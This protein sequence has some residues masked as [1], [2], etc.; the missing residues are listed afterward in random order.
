MLRSFAS[1]RSLTPCASSYN[2][3]AIISRAFGFG[4]EQSGND[5]QTLEKEKNKQVKGA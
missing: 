2:S 4:S 3:G 1:L 5:P